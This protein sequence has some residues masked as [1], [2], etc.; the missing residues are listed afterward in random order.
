MIIIGIDPGNAR[1]GYGIIEKTRAGTAYVAC[2]CIETPKTRL[3][4][5]RLL[6]LDGQL[7][8]II[9]KYAPDEAAVEDIFYFKNL[10]TVIEVAEARGVILCRL[11]A[12]RIPAFSYTP[13]Q[14]KQAVTAYGRA[15][16]DQVQKMVMRIL[17]LQHPPK[18]DDAADALAAALC[19]SALPD[20]MK[21]ASAFP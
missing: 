7:A 19:H 5:E 6:D 20:I 3:S 10:K 1:C 12:G 15:G 14:V 4:G 9:K 16:K 11:S 21:R 13:L 8:S 17:K 2:G 18:P